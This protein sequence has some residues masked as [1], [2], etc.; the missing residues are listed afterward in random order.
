MKTAFR[1]STPP[2]GSREPDNLFELTELGREYIMINQ[3]K[4][5]FKSNGQ[6][7]SGNLGLLNVGDKFVVGHV[8]PEPYIS[9]PYDQGRVSDWVAR[10]LSDN[11]IFLTKSPK[12]ASHWYKKGPCDWKDRDRD[13]VIAGGILLLPK[14]S[15][16]AKGFIIPVTAA[17]K[18]YKS[19]RSKRKKKRSKKR[20]RSKRSKR[21]RKRSKKNK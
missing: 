5:H 20:K 12:I 19:K 13:D 9:M 6:N 14:G 11:Y 17:L 1:S 2:R 18:P 7:I 10:W 15:N 8:V 21:K 3:D 16:E 4:C